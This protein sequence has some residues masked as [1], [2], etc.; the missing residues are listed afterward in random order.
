MS[1]TGIDR[2]RDQV[3]DPVTA[4]VAQDSAWVDIQ[5]RVW[6]LWFE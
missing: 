4:R 1:D 5:R 6:F 2:A 3:I